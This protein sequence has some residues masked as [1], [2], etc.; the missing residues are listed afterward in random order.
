MQFPRKVQSAVCFVSFDGIKDILTL[1]CFDVQ[2]VSL[3]PNDQIQ[4]FQKQIGGGAQ[5]VSSVF[6]IDH[7]KS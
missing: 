7:V 1:F 5:L 6:V 3:P 4:E 2:A